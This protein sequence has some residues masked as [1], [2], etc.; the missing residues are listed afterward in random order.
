MGSTLPGAV[1]PL[2]TGPHNVAKTIRN[3]ERLVPREKLILGVPFYG[4][5]WPV[6]QVGG[7]WRVRPDPARWGGVR[8]VTYASALAWLAGHPSITIHRDPVNGSWFRYT[9][10]ADRTVRQLHFEDAASAAAKFNF[11]IAEGLAGVGIWSLGNDA[12]QAGMAQAIQRTFVRPTRRVTARVG[13]GTVR[14]VRG[15]VGVTAPVV[16]VDQGSR[17]E[18]GTLTWR[19]LDPRGRTVASGRRVVALLPGSQL[20]E[21]VAVTLGRAWSLRAGTY[22]LRVSFLVGS[23]R[24]ASSTARFHQPY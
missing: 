5:S 20:R 8:G 7:T 11:A 10:A 22:Q 2:N 13:V 18:R 21:R 17:A 4:Y 19:I 16:L 9:N 1:A 12:G 6:V 23:W 24:A 15:Q 3:Y 14:L